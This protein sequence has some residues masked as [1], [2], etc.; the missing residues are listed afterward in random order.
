MRIKATWNKKERDVS[1]E[2]TAQAL[3]FIS[4]RIGMNTLLNLE[5]EGFETTTQAQRLE[6]IEEIMAF[7]IHLTD[8]MVHETMNDQD[9]AIFINAFAK[10]IADH[11][12]DNARDF[13][14]PGDYRSPFIEKMNQ[15][16]ED[17]SE[18]SFSDGKPGFNFTLYLG[19]KITEAMGEKDSKWISDQVQAIEIPELLKNFDKGI[20][21]LGIG[22]TQTS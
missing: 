15:R 12:Q 9:R 7:I 5:N 6:V 1:A 18:F 3:A 10:K 13:H 16:M 14:G 4:W 21:G 11:V 2:E 8:R 17:Y 22:G 20:R 19:N